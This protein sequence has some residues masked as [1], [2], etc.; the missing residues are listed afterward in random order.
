MVRK[1]LNKWFKQT[2]VMGALALA[3]THASA[4][5][6]QLY[7]LDQVEL[8]DSAFLHAQ[9]TNI[10]YLLQLDADKLLAPYR[11]EAG[12]E[13]RKES[14]GNWE[15]TG[16]DGH[17][18]GHYLTALSLSY[19]SSKDPRLLERLQYAIDELVIIQKAG[20]TGYL[21]GIPKGPAMWQEVAGGKIEADLFSMNK[22]WVP[23]YNIH[24]MYAGLRDA[25]LIGGQAKAKDMLLKYGE[26]T[27]WLVKNLSHE[28]IQTMLITE[29]GGMNEVFADM[30]AMSGDESYLKLARDFSQ[31]SILNP[32]LQ[33]QDRLNGL[34]ANTQIPKVVGFARVAEVAGDKKWQ[35]AAEYFWDRVVN[36][37]STA[38]GGNSVKEHFH[39][40][41]NFEAMITDI[42][43]PETCNTYNMLKLSKMLY[44]TTKDSKYLDF[45][46]RGMY[47][48]ILSSQH[49][50]HGGLV[51]FTSMRPGHY[52][53]YSDVDH[54]MWCCVGSGIE[55]HGKYGELVYAHDENNNIYVNL[56]VN[57]KLYLPKRGVTLEQQTSFPE[58]ASSKIIVQGSGEFKLM[59]RQPSWLK[60]DKMDVWVNGSKQKH[61]KI[62]NGY[63]VLNNS[64]QSGDLVEF[65]LPMQTKAEALPGDTN[66]YAVVH[67]PL[68]MASKVNPFPN[69]QL[70]FVSDDSRMGH[71]A[72]GEMCPP[73]ALPVILDDPE[74]FVKGLKP[75]AG[76]P[77][78]FTA[79]KNIDNPLAEPVVLVPFYKLHDTRYQVYWPNTSKAE[80]ADFRNKAAI[81][82]AKLAELEAKTVDKVAPGEQQP[83]SDHFYQG[84]GSE[85]GVHMGKH[86]RHAHAWFSYQLNNT[87]HAGKFIRITYFGLDNGRNFE[88]HLA[89][90]KIADVALKGDKGADFFTVDYPIPAELLKAKK[91][92]LEI[93]FVAKA[94]SIA[95]GIYGVRLMSSK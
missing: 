86:W 59:L 34:H 60:G 68:V 50:E 21:G 64:W 77:L 27:K 54:A 44:L 41:D 35:A 47:N 58:Q 94:G 84:E 90:Q 48:H 55:N 30:Y 29:H 83:E 22:R 6:L 53:M 93:K 12:L 87:G 82:A 92:K 76:Q 15:N 75:V 62:E 24:K 19:A 38:I 8:K 4:A 26:W 14:Y 2:V 36:H 91:D 52:R 17:I 72:R 73:E 89:G 78:A 51:Y 25:Y 7:S 23:W 16:L 43:G 42:E 13:P 28:Q 88:I 74:K 10:D 49:P 5:K 37:R 3:S 85:A 33:N 39:S 65:E 69:E 45:Y 1:Q 46:E 81:E 32:L 63:V 40:L 67:G 70:N 95:G 56:F 79:S 18:G 57:S 71:I 61:A 20:E 11:R 66:H 9:Q 31:L 80:L